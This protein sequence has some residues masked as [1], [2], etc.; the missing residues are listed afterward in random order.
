M[1]GQGC[2]GGEEDELGPLLLIDTAGC[3][4]E[5]DGGDDDSKRN[6]GEAAVTMAHCA[7]HVPSL[8]P[9]A[10]HVAL[11]VSLLERVIGAFDHFTKGCK[12]DR[13]I[14]RACS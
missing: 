8:F 6:Q 3:D 9:S 5:E 7:R 10:D 11:L 2:T 13:G 12:N 14:R 1:D 4:M